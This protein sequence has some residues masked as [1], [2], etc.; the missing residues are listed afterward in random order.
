MAIHRLVFATCACSF[1]VASACAPLSVNIAGIEGADGALPLVHIDPIAETSELE[2][3]HQ[4]IPAGNVTVSRSWQEKPFYA[5]RHVLDALGKKVKQSFSDEG[6]SEVVYVVQ[7]TIVGARVVEQNAFLHAM[8]CGFGVM[9]PP[10]WLY[11]LIVPFTQKDAV[12][13]VIQVYRL[14]PSELVQRQRSIPGIAAPVVETSGLVATASEELDFKVVIQQGML[15]GIGQSDD[16]DEK[17]VVD[18]TAAAL[19]AGIKRTVLRAQR[20]PGPPPAVG[21][22]ADHAGL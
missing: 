6:N 10:L 11:N 21:N 22:A 14:S 15:N 19:T 4:V 9:C 12:Q 5:K 3:R 18:A 2:T 1:I 7:T 20:K 8:M 16:I 17:T 13:A